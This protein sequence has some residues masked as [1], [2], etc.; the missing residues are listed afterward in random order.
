M[1]HQFNHLFWA[2]CNGISLSLSFSSCLSF[3]SILS[4]SSILSFSLSSQF[5]FSQTCNKDIA[6]TS[7]SFVPAGN[8]RHGNKTYTHTFYLH[9]VGLTTSQQAT[10]PPPYTHTHARTHTHACRRTHT[11][12]RTHTRTHAHTHTHRQ[13]LSVNRE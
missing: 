1:Q 2:H 3:S 10:P 5:F 7:V 8:R 13:I 11:H 4:L 6:I 9:L 12:A